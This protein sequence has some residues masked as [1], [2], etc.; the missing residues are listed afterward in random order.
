MLYSVHLDDGMTSLT[1]FYLFHFIFELLCILMVMINI[2]KNKLIHA[3]EYWL[4]NSFFVRLFLP[5]N[6]LVLTN[7]IL[8]WSRSRGLDIIWENIFHNILSNEWELKVVC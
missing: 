5:T 1:S 4:L 3:T 2:V 7:H 6:E 8:I